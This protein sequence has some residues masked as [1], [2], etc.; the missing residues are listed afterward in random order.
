M[1]LNLKALLHSI[2]DP[3][4]TPYKHFFSCKSDSELLGA[5]YWGQAIGTAFQPVLGIYE[6]ILRN[7]IHISA[8]RFA[9]RNASVSFPWYDKSKNTLVTIKGKTAEKI[10]EVLCIGEPAIR[11]HPEPTPNEVVA[12][13]SFGFWPSFLDGLNMREYPRI[14]TDTF[15]HHPHSSPRHWST[16]NNKSELIF[17]LKKIQELRNSIAHHEPIWKSHRLYGTETNWSLSVQSLRIKYDEILEIMSWCCP[18]STEIIKTSYAT[19][20]FK[21]ICSTDAVRTFMSDPINS[22][23]MERFTPVLLT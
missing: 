20:V 1:A 23:K 14:I 22:G 21:S 7:S 19:R 13:L 5:Y 9:S 2:G 8:S 12:S 17:K 11:R 6:I 10:S 16:G 18:D 3:R 4:L 15:A